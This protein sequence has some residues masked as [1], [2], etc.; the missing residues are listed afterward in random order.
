MHRANS[1][2][3][4]AGE[5]IAFREGV[6]LGLIREQVAVFQIIK[7]VVSGILPRLKVENHVKGGGA[8]QMPVDIDHAL[9][10]VGIVLEVVDE[11]VVHG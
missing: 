4:V 10:D 2:E 6:C 8:A 11:A 9:V 1:V 7:E 5:P 3:L